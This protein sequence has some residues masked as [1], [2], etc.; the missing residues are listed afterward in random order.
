[1]LGFDL[2]QASAPGLE[3]LL[4]FVRLALNPSAQVRRK[5]GFSA[6]TT[7][8]IRSASWNHIDTGIASPVL[9]H[10]AHMQEIAVVT[11]Y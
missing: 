8:R 7:R 9:V 11:F 5:T 3:E 4:A 1:M 6:S 10:T 2:H